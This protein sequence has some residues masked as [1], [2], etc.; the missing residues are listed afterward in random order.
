MLPSVMQTSEFLTLSL[1]KRNPRLSVGTAK[2]LSGANPPTNIFESSSA[3][4]PMILTAIV[5]SSLH[6]CGYPMNSETTINSS[7][8]H[9]LLPSLE[10][11]DIARSELCDLYGFSVFCSVFL[12]KADT[13]L[14]RAL[15]L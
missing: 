8:G 12:L 13:V 9:N 2:V 10:R 15:S 5:G 3:A 6:I 14:I 11:V 7:G 4:V 1:Q